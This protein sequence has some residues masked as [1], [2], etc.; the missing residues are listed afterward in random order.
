MVLEG[1]STALS[2]TSCWTRRPESWRL[3]EGNV[4]MV[5]REPLT[6][7][8]PLNNLNRPHRSTVCT[9]YS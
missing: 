8:K 7:L 5:A 3:L 2:E 1:I 6:N 4:A 9:S